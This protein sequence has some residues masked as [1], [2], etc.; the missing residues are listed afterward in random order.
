MCIQDWW[1]GWMRLIPSRPVPVDRKSALAGMGED[2]TSGIIPGAMECSTQQLSFR[3]IQA[4]SQHFAK[5]EMMLWQLVTTMM[6]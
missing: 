5:M 6:R 3:A 1:L 2:R 4:P